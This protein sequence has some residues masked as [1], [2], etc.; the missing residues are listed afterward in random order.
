MSVA[1]FALVLALST[2]FFLFS[3]ALLVVV[4]VVVVVSSTNKEA[5]VLIKFVRSMLVEV[6]PSLK[7]FC[8][9]SVVSLS[10]SSD[11]FLY[12]Y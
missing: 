4:V 7:K 3:T 6:W 8:A 9:S 2:A 5:A 1:V 12:T 10:S 11:G